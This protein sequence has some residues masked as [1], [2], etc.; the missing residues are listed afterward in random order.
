M[1]SNRE[2]KRAVAQGVERLKSKPGWDPQGVTPRSPR[3]ALRELDQASKTE[4]AYTIKCEACKTQRREEDDHTAL[5]EE[6]L[7][8]A[9]GFGGE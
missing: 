1:T 8:E 4:Q 6:H 3:E 5:C 9:L 2:K 7:K